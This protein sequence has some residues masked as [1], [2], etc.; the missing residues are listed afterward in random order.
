MNPH[1]Q[2]REY[3]SRERPEAPKD[4]VARRVNA[5]VPEAGKHEDPGQ[6]QQ[7]DVGSARD[8][9]KGDNRVEKDR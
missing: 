6:H 1:R 4:V 5:G 7:H 3:A 9:R 8:Q 2:Q